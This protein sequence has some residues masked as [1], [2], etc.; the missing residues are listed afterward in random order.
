MKHMIFF[1]LFFLLR[2]SES[3]TSVIHTNKYLSAAFT[4]RSPINAETKKETAF[5]KKGKK[6]TI[7]FLETGF[8]V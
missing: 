5:H 8:E 1:F 2:H 6:E 4:L 3:T 7:F